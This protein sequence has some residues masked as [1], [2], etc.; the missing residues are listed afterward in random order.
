MI[1][2]QPARSGG[3]HH[4]KICTEVITCIYCK[5][6]PDS[7][8]A[9]P[10]GSPEKADFL[11]LKVL[12]P[13][14]AGREGGG[15]WVADASG[16]PRL[17]PGPL[18]DRVQG[19]R[20]RGLELRGARGRLL[21]A[22]PCRLPGP[23]APSRRGCQDSRFPAARGAGRFQPQPIFGESLSRLRHPALGGGGGGGPRSGPAT[24][25]PPRCCAVPAPGPRAAGPRLW[26]ACGHA[27]A[28]S[29]PQPS[30][31]PH[32]GRR[33]G[34]PRAAWEV[35]GESSTA[36]CVTFPVHPT[37]D[38]SSQRGSDLACCARLR[39]YAQARGCGLVC[40]RVAFAQTSSPPESGDM[41]LT[42]GRSP[43][44]SGSPYP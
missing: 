44:G 6:K 23:R 19:W 25:R 10:N 11:K 31:S 7:N 8:T 33:R 42:L 24:A 40:Q 28:G 36:D 18:R 38:S 14:E 2:K 20:G 32:P 35:G 17:P 21:P 43:K 12:E 34:P 41:E 3:D 39:G 5:A 4:G 9:V 15:K 13:E 22:A 16:G 26:R 1:T 27:G 30:P 29:P 37:V